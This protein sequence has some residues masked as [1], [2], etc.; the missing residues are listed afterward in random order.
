MSNTHGCLILSAGVSTVG[1]DVTRQFPLRCPCEALGICGPTKA[2][3]PTSLGFRASGMSG[4]AEAPT[5]KPLFINSRTRLSIFD[6]LRPA[7]KALVPSITESGN[8][9][10]RADPSFQSQ[11]PGA[12]MRHA[13]YL[14]PCELLDDLRK[15]VSAGFYAV[16][17]SSIEYWPPLLAKA[18]TSPAQVVYR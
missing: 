4:L 11:F 16:C 13:T 9:Q 8:L 12:R 15:L 18:R 14:S 6:L 1:V 17:P 3:L 10:R 7:P 2:F 5:V